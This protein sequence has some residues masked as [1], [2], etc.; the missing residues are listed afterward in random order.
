MS[1]SQ[2]SALVTG[3]TSGIGRATAKKLISD[4]W[5]VFAAGR[6]QQQL[7]TL[8]TEC[9]QLPGRLVLVATDVTDNASIDAL[10]STVEAAGGVDT[11]LTIAGGALGAE[12][13]ADANIDDWRWMIE[14]NVLGS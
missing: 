12:S 7:E 11:I 2:R 8:A 14:T 9:E 4:G 6:R 10:F 1:D 3:A 5:T 13:I